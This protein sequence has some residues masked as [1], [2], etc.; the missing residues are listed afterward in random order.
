M[1]HKS[2]LAIMVF[3]CIAIFQP[4]TAQKKVNID[5]VLKKADQFFQARNYKKAL[6]LYQQVEKSGKKRAVDFELGTCYFYTT[7]LSDQIKS[8]PYL[9][10]S[11]KDGRSNIPLA[12]MYHKTGKVKKAMAMM[13]KF[14]ATVPAHDKR[15]LKKIDAEMAT[16]KNALEIMSK[17]KDIKV[18][19]IGVGINS[20]YSEY[21][22]VVATDQSVMAYTALKPNKDK[23]K[24]NQD[25]YEEIHVAY[26]TIG[27]GWSKPEKLPI[28]SEFNV[29]TAGISP[30]GQTMLIFIGSTNNTGSLYTIK[31]EGEKEWSDPVP[32]PRGV[33]SDYLESTASITPDGKT[34]Y[35]ASNRSGGYGGL[36]IYKS[37]K[38]A[39]GLWG[40][41]QNLGKD[42]NTKFNEDAP[43]IHPDKRT[44]FFTS[45]GKKSIGGNDIFKTALIGEKWIEPINMGYPINTTANDNYFTLTADGNIGYFSSDRLGGKGG[46]DVY[47][48]NMPESERNIPITLVKGRILDRET[49]KPVPTVIKVVNTETKEKVEYIYNPNT[50]TGDYLMIFPPGKSYDMIIE[51]D[52]YLPYTI[53]ISVPNQTYFYEL[54]QKIYLS[55]IKQFGVTVGQKIEINNAFY[56][57][58]AG[59]ISGPQKVKEAKLVHGDSL[60]LY[61]MMEGIIGANDTEALNYLLDLMYTTNP[62]D[63]VDFSEENKKIES[64]TRIYYYD[65]TDKSKFEEK[66]VDGESIFSLPT[67]YAAELAKE[68]KKVKPKEKAKFTSEELKLSAIVY[69]D[70]NRSDFHLKY[71][72]KLDKL[73]AVLKKHDRLGIEISGY[74]SADGDADDNK[75]LSDKRA[76][77]VLNYFNKNS[78]V[79]RRIVARGYGETSEEQ[80]LSKEAARR[81]EI[82]IVDLE[83]L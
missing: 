77:A 57:T 76:I 67:I 79:R 41:P 50:E 43:F 27:G 64:A 49:L 1:K 32:L 61:D 68:Q 38:T 7:D 8:I 55:P 19:S 18:H 25:Y 56:D 30:D 34:L 73:I 69:F 54:Y 58:K 33:N 2:I 52:G 10:K 13:Q 21:N 72:T 22:P 37:E 75:K 82:K 71:E 36:D 39:K 46:Q 48:I 14:K 44:L 40:R 11:N 35:F 17:P 70:A 26:S 53:N 60:D 4:A 24:T 42:V 78:V 20:E 6:P 5:K 47:F 29:G 23:L 9:E 83:A 31:R 59:E 63:A 3:I 66:M 16:Y 65:E 28:K 12:K 81:V 15:T 45:N 74:A 80:Q 62:L 51:S